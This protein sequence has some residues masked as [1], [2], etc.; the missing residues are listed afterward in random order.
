MHLEARWACALAVALG[1]VGCESIPEVVYVPE[2]APE[3]SLTIS[4]EATTVEAGRP[5][6]LHATRS[7]R[8]RWRLARFADLPPDACWMAELPPSEEAEVADNLQWTARTPLATF[9]V[10]LRQDRTRAVT[11]AGAGTVVLEATS[12]VW[13]GAPVTAA[14]LTIVVRPGR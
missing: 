9:N 8:G 2:T 7:T 11:F 13:C 1:L 5:L 14:P 4:A 10:D 12:A 3:V 6:V